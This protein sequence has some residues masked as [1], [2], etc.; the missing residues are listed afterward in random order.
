MRYF[1][2]LA[3]DG[4]N[5]CG[6]QKQ[7]NG[8]T[9]QGKLNVALSRMLSERVSTDGCGRTDTGVHATDFY[10]HF[11]TD[12]V[13][14][15][16][17][18][19]RLNALLPDDITIFR[20]FHVDDKANARYSAISRTYE[21]YVHHQKNPFVRTYACRIFHPMMDWQKV[22][23]ATTLIPTFSDFTTLCRVSE[24]FKNNICRVTEARWDEV[25]LPFQVGHHQQHTSDRWGS[26]FRNRDTC[27][28]FTITSNRFL[29][30][31]VRLVVGALVRIG[32]GG[33]DKDVFEAT[34]RSKE[35]F[36]FGLS[37]PAHGLYLT[38]VEYPAVVFRHSQPNLSSPLTGQ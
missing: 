24:D 11:S 21:Y 14:N 20:V 5:Y 18:A 27:M 10:A 2:H 32:S 3:Y 12:K 15:Q 33:L 13:L 23:D 38:K 31:M 1:I 36:A 7:P 8:E 28:R 37:T 29:R 22:I 16:R 17:F 19:E 30:S 6:W 26:E 25:P 35:K 4:T 34:V 9:V